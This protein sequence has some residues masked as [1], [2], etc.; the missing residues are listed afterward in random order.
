[1][2]SGNAPPLAKPLVVP[3]AGRFPTVGARAVLVIITRVED[4]EAKGRLNDRATGEAD[5][6][7]AVNA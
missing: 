4:D 7:D 6:H 1:M 3:H 2:A 5:A